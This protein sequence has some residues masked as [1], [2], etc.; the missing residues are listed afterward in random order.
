MES[1]KI[2]D[3]SSKFESEWDLY[4]LP[5]RK[6]CVRNLEALL[7]K[8][9]RSGEDT[10]QIIE[11]LAYFRSVEGTSS[12]KSDDTDVIPPQL[13][14]TINYIVKF[15]RNLADATKDALAVIGA[16]VMISALTGGFT[17]VRSQPTGSNNVVLPQP[18]VGSHQNQ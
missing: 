3:S 7:C 10:T 12:I 15:K 4:D 1:A 11:V 5:D 2:V 17:S 9:S 13:S 16:M 6:A 14:P 18:I 8:K